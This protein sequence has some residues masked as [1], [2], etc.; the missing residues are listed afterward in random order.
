MS[1]SLSPHDVS[2]SDS[3]EDEDV[4]Y[5]ARDYPPSPKP[6]GGLR[7]SPKPIGGLRR[8]PKPDVTL[9][10]QQASKRVNQIRKFYEPDQ[11]R[12]APSPRK[13][14]PPPPPP[15][16][17]PRSGSRS[18]FLADIALL[19]DPKMRREFKA[20]VREKGGAIRYLPQSRPPVLNMQAMMAEM[21]AESAKT[22]PSWLIHQRLVEGRTEE[23]IEL[24]VKTVQ[25]ADYYYNSLDSL[26]MVRM[27]QTGMGNFAKRWF[28]KTLYSRDQVDEAEINA[29]S[30]R[31][32]VKEAAEAR[33]RR[34]D[35]GKHANVVRPSN[36]FLLSWNVTFN[37]LQSQGLMK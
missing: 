8:S 34:L 4:Y 3:D 21:R 36:A 24:F 20:V 32:F 17:K 5:D 33:D 19:G 22:F 2:Y 27:I 30:S 13:P 35:L 23:A 7:R 14:S 12:R 26:L 9:E 29:W 16:P 28:Y 10:I 15:A 25:Y 11:L 6:I 18:Q 1:S 37:A 31:G